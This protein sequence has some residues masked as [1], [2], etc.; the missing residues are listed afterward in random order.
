MMIILTKS[1][2]MMVA[3]EAERS[4]M[5]KQSSALLDKSRMA[6]IGGSLIGVWI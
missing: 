4:S 1:P 5:P 3:W 6:I 2:D